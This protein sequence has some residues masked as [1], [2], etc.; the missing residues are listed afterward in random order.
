[1]NIADQ[2]Q[3][4]TIHV[5]LLLFRIA[6]LHYLS[7]I[8]K[9]SPAHSLLQSHLFYRYSRV[10]KNNNIFNFAIAMAWFQQTF[11]LSTKVYDFIN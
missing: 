8:S 9:D 4:S 10:H 2:L 3:I 1:M 7:F 5:L 11:L 6:P